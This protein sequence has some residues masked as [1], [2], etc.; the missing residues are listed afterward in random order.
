MEGPG[1]DAKVRQLARISIYTW[2]L[3]NRTGT[4]RAIMLDAPSRTLPAD[5]G[6]LIAG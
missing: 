3:T 1:D 6:T 5:R 2:E 4:N